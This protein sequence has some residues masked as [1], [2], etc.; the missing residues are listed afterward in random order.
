MSQFVYKPVSQEAIHRRAQRQGGDWESYVRS[1]FEMYR[2]KEGEDNWI[3]ILPPTWDGANHYGIS[4]WVHYSVGPDNASV[5]CLRKM[6]NQRC[7]ICE[8]AAAQEKAGAEPDDI[9]ELRPREST[10]TWIIDRHDESKGPQL[11]G[12]PV[13]QIDQEVRK[14]SLDRQTGQYTVV[15]DPYDGYDIY[16]YKNGK[17][18]NTKYTGVSKAPR[19]TTVDQYFLDYIAAVPVPDTLLWRDY[20]MVK[21]LYEGGMDAGDGYA[22]GR[23]PMQQPAPGR[24]PPQGPA[25]GRQP[26]GAP[27]RQMP[28]IPA[29]PLP[30]GPMR[31]P[32]PPP[33]R[34]PQPPPAF[35]GQPGQGAAPSMRPP[36]QGT[37]RRPI[38][39]AAAPPQQQWNQGGD[40][41]YQQPVDGYYPPQGEAA[42]EQG[43]DPAYDPSAYQG[44]EQY[45]DPSPP[46]QYTSAPPATN[47][48]QER[49]TALRQ[50]FSPPN[51]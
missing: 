1:E 41:N 40:P 25:P 29:R 48:P 51:R 38:G 26:Q 28:P 3:R 30:Q 10:L 2:P 46:G 39:P 20:A 18:R 47:S 50:R 23:E 11:W 36:P 12:M 43:Y 15:E 49:A 21:A 7:P 44:G 4:V 5:L 33:M 8:E 13:Q 17:G 45:A 14:Q 6:R 19:S 35:R 31:Q 27:Q 34:T 16:F 9:K 22:A 32:Q 42:P 37:M 24:A